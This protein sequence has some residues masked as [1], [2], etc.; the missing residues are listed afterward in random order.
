MGYQMTIR[1]SNQRIPGHIMGFER[2]G[3]EC[4]NGRDIRSHGA[5]LGFER[6]ER[7]SRRSVL[8]SK[9]SVPQ[10]DSLNSLFNI[11]LYCRPNS[12]IHRKETP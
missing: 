1:R 3:H 5:C 2:A 6:C 7:T 8:T 4:R 10:A 11:L 12:S 9:R